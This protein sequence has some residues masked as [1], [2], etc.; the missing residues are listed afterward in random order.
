[1]KKISKN[2]KYILTDS[3]DNLVSMDALEWDQ[4][5]IK[6][7]SKIGAGRLFSS[8]NQLGESSYIVLEKKYENR[9]EF[10]ICPHAL[11]DGYSALRIFISNEKF[12]KD[13]SSPKIKNHDLL[14]KVRLV[15]DAIRS[16]KLINLNWKKEKVES[17]SSRRK[18][19]HDCFCSIKFSK[20][21]VALLKDKCKKEKYGMNSYLL[22]HANLVMSE[23][24]HGNDLRWMIPVSIRGTVKH[25]KK[26]DIESSY[27]GINLNK[28]SKAKYIEQNIHR[29]IKKERHWG[30]WY[31]GKVVASLGKRMNVFFA[32]SEKN[33]EKMPWFGS[34]SN[35]M[36]WPLK[37]DLEEV[38]KEKDYDLIIT[39]SIREKRAI[40]LTA[41]GWKNEL[42][43]TLHIHDILGY[44]KK[45]GIEMLNRIKMDALSD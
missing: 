18:L 22:E 5:N 38:E 11:Y 20:D 36:R 2:K 33:S 21:E 42:I 41:M 23:L 13:L 45:E 24:I 25:Q 15:A 44:S 1:M 32:K 19:R 26:S 17:E 27:I 30:Y 29:L 31:L 10:M 37:E 8:I 4:E 35:L 6:F 40:G 12:Q 28:T 39:P 34:F 16:H 43:L 7:S 9:S 14:K 3:L